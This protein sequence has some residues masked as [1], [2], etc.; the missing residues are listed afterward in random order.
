MCFACS[1]MS[2]LTGISSLWRTHVSQDL[3]TPR[4]FYR[5]PGLVWQ[6]Y[7]YRRHMALNVEPNPAH[8]ALAE[9]ARRMP[10]FLALTQN[11]DGLS[12]RAGHPDSSLLL[13]H[14][15]LFD[16]KCSDRFCD[17]KGT[18]Y[19]DPVSV[20]PTSQQSL[21]CEAYPARSCLHSLFLVVDKIRLPSNRD[22]EI[23]DKPT[24]MSNS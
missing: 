17:Y 15:S 3:A 1:S 7:S 14:G 5:D 22:K 20:K 13:L 2:L 6:F 12:P 19:V 11:V 23:R 4:A 9:L 24:A 18:N 16:V 8:Y 21:D 10:G